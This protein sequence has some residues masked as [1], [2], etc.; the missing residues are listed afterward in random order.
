MYDIHFSVNQS[1][2]FKEVT[3]QQILNKN[4]NVDDN[5]VETPVDKNEYIDPGNHEAFPKDSIEMNRKTIFIL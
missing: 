1:V 4:V 5:E 2:V 3:A